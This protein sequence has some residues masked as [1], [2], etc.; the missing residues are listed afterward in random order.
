[1]ALISG[2]FSASSIL[3]SSKVYQLSPSQS[4]ECC[5]T[6]NSIFGLQGACQQQKRYSVSSILTTK[7]RGCDTAFSPAGSWHQ[8]QILLGTWRVDTGQQSQ[9]SQQSK[10]ESAPVFGNRTREAAPARSSTAPNI[11]SLQSVKDTAKLR[12]EKFKVRAASF[13]LSTFLC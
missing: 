8:A 6:C 10:A 7:S 11:Q 4:V 3:P 9:Q 13:S 12:I 5:E 1:M 2:C